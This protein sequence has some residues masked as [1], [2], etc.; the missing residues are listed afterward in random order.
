MPAKGGSQW[1]SSTIGR[2]RRALPAV[3]PRP[4]MDRL[5]EGGGSRGNR[6]FTRVFRPVDP[7]PGHAGEG[8]ITVGELDDRPAK[9]GFARRSSTPADGSAPRRR[10][11]TGEPWVHPRVPTR[12]P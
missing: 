2:R 1:A 5:P 10:G 7:D 11:L 3:A 9:T 4:L 8:R 12:R 6:G